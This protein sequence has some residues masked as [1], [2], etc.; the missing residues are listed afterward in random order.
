MTFLQVLA[1]NFTLHLRFNL[2]F[3]PGESCLSNTGPDA[4]QIPPNETPVHHNVMLF[5]HLQPLIKRIKYHF[6]CTFI[7]IK[8]LIQSQVKGEANDQFLRIN[9][10]NLCLTTSGYILTVL[11]IQTIIEH[12]KNKK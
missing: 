8:E 6:H 5:C 9:K 3:Y 11:P 10:L 12:M 1:H 7:L 2:Q 4:G